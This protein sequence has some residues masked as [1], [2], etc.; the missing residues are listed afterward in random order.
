MHSIYR[1][2]V[3]ISIHWVLCAKLKRSSNNKL[4][5]LDKYTNLLYKIHKVICLVLKTSRNNK[6]ISIFLDSEKT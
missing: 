4:I 5:L 1:V 2:Y 3:A 6:N